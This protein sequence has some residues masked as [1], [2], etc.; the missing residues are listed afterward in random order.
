[1]LPAQHLV[2]ATIDENERPLSLRVLGAY[3][4][5]KG[6]RT[7]LLVLI[8][9]LASFAE[10]VHFSAAE[11]GQIA[12]LLKREQVS[13]LGFYLMTATL[14]PYTQLVK[15]LRAAGYRG[16][17]MAGGVH[18]TLCPAESLVKGADYAVQGPGEV[19]LEMILSGQDPASIPGLVWRKEGHVQVN[20]IAPQQKLDLNALPNPI[21]RF[22][23]DWI[24]VDGKLRRLTWPLHARHASWDGTYYD[25]ATSRGCIYTCTY[26]CNVYGAPVQRASVDHVM[27]ELRSLREREPRIAGINIQ[28]DSFYANSDEWLRSFC[29]RMKSEVGLPFIVRMIP[30]FVTRERVVLL[31]DAGMHYVTMGLEASDRLNKQ[32]FNRQETA[33]SF[34][35]AARVVLDAGVY[36]STD[37]LIHN[38]YEREDDLREMALTLNAL[39]RPNWGVVALSLTPFPN[40]A[41][42]AR[43][44]QDGMLDRF[45]TDPYDSMLIPSRPGGYLTPRFWLLLNTQILARV[46]PTLG[47]RLIAQGPTHPA[48]V[49]T[50]E[51]LASYLDRTRRITAWLRRRTPW[52][53]AA[54]ARA[55]TKKVSSAAP[56]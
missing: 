32:L 18:A 46:S 44:V 38:P 28:D 50:V 52:L 26:C 24:L 45:A 25:I 41:L 21:F 37:I 17:I 14:R 5:S 39:P 3:A 56:A 29:A 13:H 40:T 34:L 1:M 47:A 36:L 51:Q 9:R 53:Y 35:K 30:R 22:D 10:P 48:A 11:V 16:V 42:R 31:K 19:P 15:A 55:L 54:V 2:L 49:Q 4:E 8:K 20:A 7:S 23:R 33:A 6:T 12:S 27:A 43:C